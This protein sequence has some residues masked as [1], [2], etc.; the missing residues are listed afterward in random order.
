MQFLAAVGYLAP[1]AYILS[2]VT[3]AGFLWTFVAVVAGALLCSGVGLV[4]LTL[5]AELE[6]GRLGQ[7]G[8]GSLLFAAFY[9]AMFFGLVRWVCTSLPHAER[10]SLSEAALFIMVAIPCLISALVGVYFV[11]PLTESLLWA[12]VWM[13]RRP[14]VRRFLGRWRRRRP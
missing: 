6:D 1:M 2:G 3:E 14:R 8:V 4:W 11:L 13:L 5:W 10:T 12:A 9:A 7:F